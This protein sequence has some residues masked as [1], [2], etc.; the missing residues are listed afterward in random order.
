MKSR[1]VLLGCL[2]CF[3][4]CV[5][6]AQPSPN[7]DTPATRE[8]I[9]RMFNVMNI[10]AQTRQVMDQVMQQMRSMNR[11]QMKKRRPEITDE[12][13]SRM[14]KES[15]EIAKSFPVDE[16]LEDMIP[17]YQKHL[18][19]ADVD[20]IISFYS[21]PTGQK[22]LREMPA[23]MSEGMQAAYPRMQKN[24]D[25]IMKRMDEK[26]SEQQRKT[27]PVQPAPAEKQ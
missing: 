10:E 26:A 13:L 22:M 14:D 6:V 5:L 2:V 9:S 21:S 16:L 20:A 23:M 1:L 25:A 17:V 15:E 8:D 27:V 12:E 18:S 24:L 3:A 11:E 19:R 4:A 7:A